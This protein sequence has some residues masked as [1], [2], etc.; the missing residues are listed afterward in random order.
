MDTITIARIAMLVLFPVTFIVLL[1]TM[2]HLWFAVR[3]VREEKKITAGLLGPFAFLIPT[4]F[5]DRAQLHLQRLS[6]WLPICIVVFPALF[7]LQEL[8]TPE[9]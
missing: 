8:V 1:K 5:E 7:G 2:Y 9:P 4:L 3:G 6:V